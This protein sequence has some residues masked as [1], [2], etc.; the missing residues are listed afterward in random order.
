MTE[1]PIVE[2]T[3]N[4]N[5]DVGGRLKSG[6][7]LARIFLEVQGNDE[8]AA[9]KALENT[10]FENMNSE[11]NVKLLEVKLYKIKKDEKEKFYSGVVEI[12][13]VADDFR[14]FVSL[15]MRYGPS[16]I[17]IIE[18]EAVHLNLDEMQSLL[19]DVSETS[20]IFSSKILGMMKDEERAVLNKK[21]VGE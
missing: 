8:D 3:F 10:I 1:K 19:A 6:G 9:K 21:I 13:L 14:W 17:E 5:L 20:Q 7:I 12:R 15:V 4:E 2:K 18:P 11:P 16:A